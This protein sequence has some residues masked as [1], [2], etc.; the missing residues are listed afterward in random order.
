MAT[1]KQTTKSNELSQEE[2]ATLS[3]M[4]DE[5][6]TKATP[7]FSLASLKINGKEGGYFKTVIKDGELQV[8]EDGKALLEAVANPS[9]II[10]RPR[11]CYQYIGADYQ[12]YSN[13][14]GN[15]P[16]SQFTIFEKR[17]TK[18]GFSNSIVFQGTPGEIKVKFP[19][20]K[21]IQILYFLLDEPH[22]LVRL[23]V[24]GMSLGKLFDY[25]KEFNAT[26][27]LFQFKTIR[28]EEKGKNQ[29]GKFIMSTFKKG[30][31]VK[32]L[33]EV[34]ENIELIAKKIEEIET[35]FAERG[36]EIEDPTAEGE[37]PAARPLDEIRESMAKLNEPE[38]ETDEKAEDEIDVSKIPFGN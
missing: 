26:E 10:L 37:R 34:K 36:L 17:E 23:K 29:F 6:N 32:D 30:E 21:M 28:G 13:E 25:W 12:L 8:G 16:K 14:G 24:K 27:H 35:H 22:E 15:T 31:K 2:L 38:E 1:K 18:K 3:E 33:S 4:S 11:K 20:I 9:G 5:K 7:R 19:E